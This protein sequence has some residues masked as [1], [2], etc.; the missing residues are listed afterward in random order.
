MNLFGDFTI[1]RGAILV[2]KVGPMVHYVRWSPKEMLAF[3]DDGKRGV[4]VGVEATRERC[5]DCKGWIV[6]QDGTAEEDPARR[7]RSHVTPHWCCLRD[8]RRKR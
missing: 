7:F 2:P 3:L 1:G 8:E 6:H 5:P 4:A